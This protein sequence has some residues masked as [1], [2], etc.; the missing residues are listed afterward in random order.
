MPYSLSGTYSLLPWVVT[1]HS[2]HFPAIQKIINPQI[3]WI[4]VLIIFYFPQYNV[5]QWVSTI[6]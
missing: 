2:A 6:V 4:K 3:D 1:L 5:P